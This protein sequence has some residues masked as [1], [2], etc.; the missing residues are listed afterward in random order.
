MFFINFPRRRPMIDISYLK[1]LGAI[2]DVSRYGKLAII[3]L[4]STASISQ[5]INLCIII[6][7]GD[8][9]YRNTLANY[10]MS[11]TEGKASLTR[12]LKQARTTKTFEIP[13]A[14]FNETTI[15][16]FYTHQQ[17]GRQSIMFNVN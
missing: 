7:Q 2:I 6:K 17:L 10:L 8:L 3:K 12:I 13:I 1:T 4:G 16:L 9:V 14:E 11:H 15:E 5:F